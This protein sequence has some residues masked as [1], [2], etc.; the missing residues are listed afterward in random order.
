[1]DGIGII[2]LSGKDSFEIIKKI[3]IPKNKNNNIKGYSMKYGVIVD[4]K[5]N[6][7]DEVLIS[8]FVEP[9]SY[10][11]ENMCEINAHGGN[12]VVKKILELC[13]K[14]GA[15]I[16]EPGEFTKRAFL[17]GRID[18]SQ[19]EAVIDI[20]NSKTSKEAISAGK[21]LEGFLSKE[22]KEIKED[23]FSIMT[24]IE[25]GIDYPEYD[26]EEVTNEKAIRIL[27]V[28][29]DKLQKL[30]L[31]FENGKIIKEG[32][33]VA[34]IGRPNVGKSSLLNAILK[35]ER[36]IV[37]DIEGTTRDTIEELITIE[38]IPLKII[39]T[40]GIRKTDDLIEKM[41]IDKAKSIAKEADL[42]IAIFDASKE[43]QQEDLDIIQIAQTKTSIILLNKNDLEVKINEN[44]K[45]FANIKKD[46]IK[47]SAINKEGIEQINEKIVEL[48]NLKRIDVDNSITITN[49]RHKN[50]I[51]K[52]IES[53]D[54][55]I[56]TIH[57]DM[58][59]DIVAIYLKEI[60]ENILAITGENVT[61]DI[62]NDIFS[63]FC[64]GK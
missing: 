23:V 7:I 27:N 57:E 62:I 54:Q 15:R 31:S 51:N 20:I 32:I 47:I 6:Y 43:L 36:A 24:D 16:A 39:D 34:I 40:A 49:E 45:E 3:F 17:N 10:T 29:R 13:L 25:A 42:I 55:S 56:K 2:R 4:E 5:G 19:A 37:T 48:F 30:Y 63:K 59:I 61:E 64:L 28:V 11:T 22:I 33:K 52:A 38:G 8:F 26:I 9:K 35:E 58:P 44:T 60:L 41:G 21:Q 14:N 18:L 53:T 46:I 1:M 12:V 50:L